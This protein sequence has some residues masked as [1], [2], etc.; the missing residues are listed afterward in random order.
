MTSQQIEQV[1]LLEGRPLDLKVDFGDILTPELTLCLWNTAGSVRVAE[2]LPAGESMGSHDVP[3][4][5]YGSG[6]TATEALQRARDSFRLR[7]AN[8]NEY[9][10]PAD[11][12]A[13]DCGLAT[14]GLLDGSYLDGVAGRSEI[15]FSVLEDRTVVAQIPVLTFQTEDGRAFGYGMNVKAAIDDLEQTTNG[16]LF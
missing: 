2:I 4:L 9:M 11:I 7:A 13:A 5:G 3:K 15:T 12:A 6:A 10:T 8:G 16:R 14:G 1:E